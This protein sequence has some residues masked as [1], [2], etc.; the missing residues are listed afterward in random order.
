MM[1]IHH[2]RITLL[3]T[4]PKI[5]RSVAVPSGITL[6]RLHQVIQAAMGWYDLHLH[7]FRLYDP[8]MKK[9]PSE[10]AKLFAE[11]RL[12]EMEQAIRGERIF[13]S[14]FAP[15]GTELDPMGMAEENEDEATLAE[16]CPAPK[17]KAKLIYEYDFGDGWEHGIETL[18]IEDAEPET[19][20]PFCAGGARACPPEDCGGVHG[21][22]YLLEIQAD[23]NHPEHQE[24][25]EWLGD[26]P[27]DPEAFDLDETNQLM[28]ELRREWAKYDRKTAGSKRRK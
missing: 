12:S 25:M 8:A 13:A 6:G 9:K 4:K 28:A 14:R 11:Q 17:S 21:Y 7:H 18:N 24:R 2:L 10:L 19:A 15:D 27:I 16:V 23:P 1:T 22:D 26:D 5:W 20:Y 3:H